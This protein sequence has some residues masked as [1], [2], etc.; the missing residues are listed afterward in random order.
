MGRFIF[1]VKLDLF[2]G[3]RILGEGWGGERLDGG[4]GRVESLVVIM[5]KI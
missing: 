5:C 1:W 2:R 3:R 4:E